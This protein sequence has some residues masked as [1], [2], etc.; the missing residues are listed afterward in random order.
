[1]RVADARAE[2]VVNAAPR[3]DELGPALRPRDLAGFIGHDRLRENLAVFVNAARRRGAAMD[4]TLFH[5]PPGLGKTTLAHILA[6]ELGVSLR[7]TSGPALV[8]AGDL[9]SVLTNL[10]PRSILFVD[11][12]HRLNPSV[13]ETLYPALEDFELDLVIGTGPAARIVRITLQPFTL[14]GATTRLGLIT[15]PLRDRFGI[16]QRLD[17]YEPHDLAQIVT[18][19]GARLGIAL[20]AD[21]AGEIAARARGVPR[22]AI[23]MLRRIADFAVV[24]G[25]AGI[26]RALA[27]ES[28]RRMEVD[29][30][31]LDSADRR[32]LSC[33][34]ENYRGGPA[35]VET[36]A[37]ALSETR[38][39][40]EDVIEPFLLQQGLLQR[41]PR[42]RMLTARAWQHLGLAPMPA[43]EGR[44]ALGE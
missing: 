42:G 5:G 28:L 38:D 9:A 14:V 6:N 20:G 17:F 4:H 35:G 41:T 23:R 25:A 40:I 15:T 29:E 30:L 36:L 43:G 21:G 37:A 18:R 34:A 1:M 33:L 3:E 7:V 31:G 22:V 11:E 2:S 44:L 13:E 27:D 24:R 8:R 32:Y 26:D 10:E 16:Q 19:A 12:I 39:A